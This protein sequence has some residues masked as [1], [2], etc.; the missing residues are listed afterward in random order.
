MNLKATIE[1]WKKAPFDSTTQQEVAALENDPDLLQDAFY[2]D[3]A[4]GTGGM[5]G[6]MGVGTNRINRYTLGKAAQGLSN[7]LQQCYPEENIK[8]AIAYD[9]RNNSRELATE[10][11]KVFSA[12]HIHVYLFSELRPTPQLSFSV[13][14]FNMH[15]GIVLTASHNPPEYNGFKVYWKDGGQIVPPV[16]SELI[17]HIQQLE[18]SQIRFDAQAEYMHMFDASDDDSYHQAVI[19]DAG[20]YGRQPGNLNIVFTPLHGTSVTAI[21]QVLE[22][23]GYSHVHIIESQQ[24]PDGNFPTV[25]SPNPEEPQALA[26][27]IE[28]AIALQADIAFGTDPDADRLGIVVPDPEGNYHLLNGNQT[29]VVLTDFLIRK[30]TL[31]PNTYIA[32]TIVSTPM[33]QAMAKHHGIKLIQTL[34]GFKWIG[35]EIEQNTEM[36]FLGGGEESYGYLVGTKVRDKD[37]VSAALLACEI[38]SSLKSEGK[39]FYTYLIDCYRKYG[40]FKERLV[41]IKKEGQKGA[42][43]IQHTMERYRKNPPVSIADINI[44]CIEDYAKQQRFFPDTMEIEAIALPQA[45]VL[46]FILVDGSEIALRPS[47]TEPKIKLYCSVQAPFSSDENW[48]TTEQILEKKLDQLVNAIAI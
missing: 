29:M 23:A 44:R 17:E 41:A 38:A 3:L 43:A 45:N 21:P 31:S 22:K 14:H 27:A 36:S 1:T 19:E 30:N 10:V 15:C 26:L 13:R 37:A 47:G 39:S 20:G 35:A 32:S 12:N 16:D 25:S 4:F 24:T 6:I 48:E 9:C 28:K 42:Q 33:M 18:Y 11:A 2:Q 40:A 34:T 8:V 5:R 46:K 7:Y